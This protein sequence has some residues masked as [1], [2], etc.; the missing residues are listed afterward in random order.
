M[1]TRIKIID[2]NK[3]F[4]ALSIL[5]TYFALAVLKSAHMEIKF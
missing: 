1:L 2:C 4:V 3:N 5:L